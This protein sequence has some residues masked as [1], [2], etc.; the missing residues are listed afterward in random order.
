LLVNDPTAW[1]HHPP[2]RAL[3]NPNHTLHAQE[4]FFSP[5]SPP[6]SRRRQRPENGPSG[7]LEPYPRPAPKNPWFAAAYLNICGCHRDRK[8]LHVPPPM[9]ATSKRG[10]TH[11]LASPLGSVQTWIGP[12]SNPS[13]G[14]LGLHVTSQGVHINNVKPLSSFISAID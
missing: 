10:L 1:G 13:L 3:G 4:E 14:S 6:P 2:D 8:R 7:R 9:D 12:P 5:G 11:Y